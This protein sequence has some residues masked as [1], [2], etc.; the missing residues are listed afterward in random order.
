MQDDICHPLQ[1]DVM[2]Q[3]MFNANASS[4]RL[5]FTTDMDSAFQNAQVVIPK[6]WGGFAHYDKW[7]GSEEQIRKMRA[8]G[9]HPRTHRGARRLLQH[10]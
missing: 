8:R 7:E 9:G 4:S 6:N 1:Q 5:V 10:R 2:Q 3:A